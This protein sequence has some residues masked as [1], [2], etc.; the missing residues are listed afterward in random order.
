MKSDSIDQHLDVRG[1]NCPLPL[2]KAKQALHSLA[3]GQVLQVVATD[4][5]SV[6]D[7][8]AYTDQSDHELLEAFTED[9]EYFYV[10]RRG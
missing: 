7:F 5:G 10:I 3:A 8:K 2:L 4:A 6:R 1:L 9:D